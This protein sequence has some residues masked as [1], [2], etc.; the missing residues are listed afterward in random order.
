[1]QRRL[2]WKLTK[3]VEFENKFTLNKNKLELQLKHMPVQNIHL[4]LKQYHNNNEN[5]HAHSVTEP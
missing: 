2:N 5:F 3:N 4:I 1:M